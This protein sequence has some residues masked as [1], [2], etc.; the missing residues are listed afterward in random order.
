MTTVQVARRL[1]KSVRT[2]H[3]MVDTGRLPA[4]RVPGYKGPL[5]FDRAEVERVRQDLERRAGDEQAGAA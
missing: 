1:G 4:T 2:V 5:L 3:R